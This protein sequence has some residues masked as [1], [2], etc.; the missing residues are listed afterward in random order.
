MRLMSRRSFLN[1]EV[2][3]GYVQPLGPY[4]SPLSSARGLVLAEDV[5]AGHD[6][7]NL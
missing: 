1:V 5:S 7:H 2:V 6:L 3:L 4:P